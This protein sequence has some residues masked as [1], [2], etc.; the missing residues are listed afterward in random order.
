MNANVIKVVKYRMAPGRYL[1]APFFCATLVLA[2]ALVGC[3]GDVEA[4]IDTH[5]PNHE[6]RLGKLEK[7]TNQLDQ[8]QNAQDQS[9]ALTRQAFA[10]SMR[11]VDACQTYLA[12][13]DTRLSDIKPAH[14]PEWQE[15]YDALTNPN[16]LADPDFGLGLD[17]KPVHFFR[18]EQQI[19]DVTDSGLRTEAVALS[20]QQA[21]AEQAKRFHDINQNL[22]RLSRLAAQQSSDFTR[23]FSAMEGRIADLQQGV[24]TLD[25]TVGDLQGVVGRLE[26][27]LHV[28][29][30]LLRKYDIATMDQRLGNAE[31]ALVAI[32][33]RT[34][35]LEGRV[36]VNEGDLQNLNQNVIDLELQITKTSSD[37]GQLQQRVEILENP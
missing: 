21:I 8:D 29:E 25:T 15:M 31:S 9:I 37:L 10:E 23:R 33:N 6:S 17:H 1:P 20:N 35:S 28:I 34:S 26:G 24:T 16:A 12:K 7:I 32:E 11:T 14:L 19:S 5:D 13:L 30:Q 27:R 36:T 4:E 18:H 3:R 2:V 22:E